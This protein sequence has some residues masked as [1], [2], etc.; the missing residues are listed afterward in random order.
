MGGS[1]YHLHTSVIHIIKHGKRINSSNPGAKDV[2][3]F[4]APLFPFTTSRHSEFKGCHRPAQIH[5]FL[6]HSLV[7]PNSKEPKSHILAQV[8]WPMVH[9]QRFLFGKPVEV[10]CNNLNEPIV[11]NTFLPV[12]A[13]AN[14]I[15]YSIDELEVSHERVLIVIPL[16]D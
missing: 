1:L 2:N 13:I 5:H 11:D 16:V 4:A 15:I 10:W 7:L 12:G 9:P 3:I 6:Q 8:T 14:R